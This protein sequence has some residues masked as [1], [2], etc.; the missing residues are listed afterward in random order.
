ME[1]MTYNA[2]ENKVRRYAPNCDFARLHKAYEF[3]KTAHSGQSRES[4]EPYVTH[5]LEVASIVADMELDCDALIGALLHDVVEDTEVTVSDIEKEFGSNVALIVDGLTKLSKLHF[6]SKEEQQVENLRKMF[7]AMAKDVRVII[8]KLADRLHNMRTLKAKSEEKQREKARE[9]LEVYAALAHRL[10]MSK[11]KWELEDISLR[12]LDPIAYKEIAESINQKRREREQYIAD[13]TAALEVGLENRGIKATVTGRAKHFYSIY[14]KMYTQNKSIDELYDLFAV[15][16]IVDTV[17]DCYAVLG[18]VHEL[19]YPMPGRFKDYIAMPKPN[20]YQS[21][22]TTVIG[23]N[24]TPFEIQIRTWEMHRVAEYGI[25]AHW[26]YKEGTTDASDMDS[27]LAWIRQILEIQNAAVDSDDFMRALKIDMFAD[28]VFVFTPKGDVLNLPAGSTPI[29]FAFAIHSA[30]GCRMMGAKVNGKIATLDY[31]LQNGDIVEIMTSSAVHGP[32]RDWLKICKTSQARSKINQWLKKERREENVMRG[33]ELTERELKRIGVS[34]A[35]L[36]RPE[37]VETLCKRY[38]FANLDDLY[39]AVGYGGLAVNKAISYLREKYRSEMH[40]EVTK[41]DGTP[42]PKPGNAP[43]KTVQKKQRKAYNNNGVVVRGIENCLVRL[44]R[45]CNPVPGDDIVGYITRGRGVSVHRLDCPNIKS[46]GEEAQRLIEVYW[47]NAPASQSYLTE[48]QIASND[49][50]G[51]LSDVT[52]C[53]SDIKI[54]ITNINL[55]ITKEQIALINVTIE[56]KSTDD[57]IKVSKKIRQIPGVFE[58][59]RSNL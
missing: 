50:T 59:K 5:P 46:T 34:H 6:A 11:I 52:A 51:L 15:R 53:I 47:E 16:A 37:W 25:A 18:M 12:Y 36:F 35:D 17:K 58:V 54:P 20:M 7:L 44:S 49:R 21:L 24:G 19:Y 38:G 1:R 27:K 33:K 40:T 28:E 43:H 31:V 48:L 4:G 26:K 23:P 29:D 14:R 39:A 41:S 9:T 8:I 30:V 2:L 55:R 22:H 32:S 42:A 56:I 3:A 10:G 45:C 13:I 57:L